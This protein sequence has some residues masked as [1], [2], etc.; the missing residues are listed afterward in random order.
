MIENVETFSKMLHSFFIRL[1]P[2]QKFSE[3]KLNKF[4]LLTILLFALH[5][6][7]NMKENFPA[8]KLLLLFL[9]KINLKILLNELYAHLADSFDDVKALFKIKYLNSRTNSTL[10]NEIE[11]MNLP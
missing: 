8:I 6:T 5:T 7:E 3:K 9:F 10:T 4:Y 2:H 1:L 11:N